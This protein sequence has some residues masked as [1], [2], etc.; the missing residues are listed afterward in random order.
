MKANPLHHPL[1]KFGTNDFCGTHE[2]RAHRFHLL[3]IQ[4]QIPEGFARA[5]PARVLIKRQVI[6]RRCI[7]IAPC[8][9]GDPPPWEILPE[10]RKQVM[11][12]WPIWWNHGRVRLLC[13][14]MSNYNC[15]S[16]PK[17]SFVVEFLKEEIST[18]YTKPDSTF[19]FRLLVLVEFFKALIR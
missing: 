6:K 14:P 11:N 16:Y 13:D 4:I 2:H 8:L 3:L 15:Q 7:S 17:L 10:L 19:I 12:G 5:N 9:I 1:T 18:H